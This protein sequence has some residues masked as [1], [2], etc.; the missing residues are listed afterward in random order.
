[1]K[2]VRRKEYVFSQKE[3]FIIRSNLLAAVAIFPEAGEPDIYLIP[4][5][6]WLT[7]DKV[8]VDRDYEGLASKPEF[9]LNLSPK[10]IP[11][12]APFAMGAMVAELLTSPVGTAAVPSREVSSCRR[13]PNPS[14]G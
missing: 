1:M 6:R 9:G 14:A 8:F 2:S 13:G 10:N 7:V 5:S 12:L 4:A 3:K 11:A